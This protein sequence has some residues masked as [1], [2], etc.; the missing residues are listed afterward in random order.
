MTTDLETVIQDLLASE[1]SSPIRMIGFNTAEHW[2]ED[3]SEDIAREI[4]RR[5]DLQQTEVPPALR[6][7]ID[8]HIGDR[9]QLTLRLA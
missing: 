9:R 4:Q 5:C 2:S 3:V 7:F 8:R 1:Y 6:V